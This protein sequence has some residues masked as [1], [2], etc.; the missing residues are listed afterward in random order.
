MNNALFEFNFFESLLR[1]PLMIE[2]PKTL[3]K[4]LQQ[5]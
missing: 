1:E 4:F 3:A 2:N 5:L